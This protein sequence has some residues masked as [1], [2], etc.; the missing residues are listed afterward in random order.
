MTLSAF[1]GAV[2]VTIS[3]ILATKP[4]GPTT[5]PAQVKLAGMTFNATNG[6]S[7]LRPLRAKAGPPPW[8]L[9]S[10]ATVPAG[11]GGSFLKALAHATTLELANGSSRVISPVKDGQAV[12][13][14]LTSHQGEK[15]FLP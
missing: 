10:Q 6:H 3:E 7:S 11:H 15:Y 2:T 1:R 9:V 4:E 14:F 5:P 13:T 8:M 12:A